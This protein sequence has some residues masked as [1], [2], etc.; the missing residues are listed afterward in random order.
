[1][2]PYV[3]LDGASNERRISFIAL[4]VVEI[5]PK[6]CSEP[7]RSFEI[8]NCCCRRDAWIFCVHLSECHRTSFRWQQ[9]VSRIKKKCSHE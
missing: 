8:M 3:E 2:S 9:H 1:M 4:F 6:R 5:W 7:N